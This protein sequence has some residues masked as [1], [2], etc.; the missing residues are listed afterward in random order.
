MSLGQCAIGSKGAPSGEL[1]VRGGN[2]LV[3]FDPSCMFVNSKLE[4]DG[5][6]MILGYCVCVQVCYAASAVWGVRQV[7]IFDGIVSIL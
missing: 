6:R 3:C 1:L 4:G 7:A 5:R 2:M